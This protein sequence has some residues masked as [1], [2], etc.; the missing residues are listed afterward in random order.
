M[1]NS[2]GTN[3]KPMQVLQSNDYKKFVVL[4]GNRSINTLHFN[5]LKNSMSENYL[6]SP[7]IVNENFE[8]IDGQHRLKSC[9]ELLLPVF[10]IVCKGYGLSEIHRYNANSKNWTLDDYMAGYIQLGKKEYEFYKTFKDRY[11]FSHGDCLRMLSGDWG[12]DEVKKFQEGKLRIKKYNEA[13]IIA[14]KIILI[15]PLYEG[16]KRRSF[17]GALLK[18]LKNPSFDIVEFS[19]K[20]KFQQSKLYDCSTTEQYVT[21]IEEIYNFKRR[22]KVSLKYAV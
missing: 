19:E 15:K 11:D 7:I 17:V 12:G 5:R 9:E 4:E 6:I 3:A 8:V 21:L 13:C 14:E 18:M 20:L 2:N 16:W 1:S 22:E 10:Y